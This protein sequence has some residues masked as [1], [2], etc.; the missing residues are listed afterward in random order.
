MA[1]T[2]DYENLTNNNTY[3]SLRA[4]NWA[5]ASKLL[6]HALDHGHGLKLQT[7]NGQVTEWHIWNNNQDA[8]YTVFQIAGSYNFN[9]SSPRQ[10]RDGLKEAYE[11]EFK[12]QLDQLRERKEPLKFFW[13]KIARFFGGKTERMKRNDRIDKAIEIRTNT[14][15]RE[16]MMNAGLTNEEMLPPDAAEKDAPL[17][18]MNWDTVNAYVQSGEIPQLQQ[19]NVP[20]QGKGNTVDHNSKPNDNR[21]WFENAK[22]DQAKKLLDNALL[23]ADATRFKNLIDND[24]EGATKDLVNLLANIQIHIHPP[25]GSKDIKKMSID[26]A[27][28]VRG[29]IFSLLDGAPQDDSKLPDFV[30][31]MTN[32]SLYFRQMY[33]EYLDKEQEGRSLS[34]NL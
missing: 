22:K 31:N 17:T 16:K 3:E 5:N 19:P 25:K 2:F 15:V 28:L 24:D 32:T 7:H 14:Y 27:N 4:D 9:F 34:S 20:V 33:N 10:I 6:Q 11:E 12:P 30:R 8:F 21:A 1:N 26:E 13:D 18:D 23:E 29:K